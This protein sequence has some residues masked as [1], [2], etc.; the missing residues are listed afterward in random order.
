M[1]DTFNDDMRPEFRHY[2]IKRKSG[3]YPWGSGEDEY[4]RALAFYEIIGKLEAR[5][6]PEKEMY[7]ALGL[8]QDELTSSHIRSTRTIA[9]E[10]KV[11]QETQTAVNMRERGMS[12]KAIAEETGMSIATVRNRLKNSEDLK[13][14]MLTQ[15][16]SVLKKTVDEH[17]IVDIGKGT[18]L[19]MGVS[20]EKLKAA[21][22]LLRDEDYRTHS[23]PISNPGTRFNTNTLVLVKPGTTWGDAVKMAGKLHTMGSWTED[24]GLT[25]RNLRDPISLSSKRLKVEFDEDGGSNSDGLIRVRPGVEDVSMGKNTYAQVRILVD[26]SHYLKGMAVL[27]HKMEPGVDVIFSTN[28]SRSVGKLGALKEIEADPDNPFGSNIKR[29]I[30][31]KDPKTGV[32]KATSALN[33]VNEE[34]DWDTWRKSVPSQM[35]A[36]QPGA[37][38]ASQLQTTR[39]QAR[40]RL[41]EINQITN[42]VVRKKALADYADQV[43]ADAVDLRAAQFPR[44]QTKVIIPMPKLREDEIYAPDYT[45][46]ERVV[47]IRY[48]HGGRF[49]IPEVTVNNN[50]RIAKSLLGNAR[51]AIGI[52]PK[53]AERLSGADFDGDT[54]IV[55]PN[56]SGKIKSAKSLSAK[57]TNIYETNLKNFNPKV[58]Y[59]GFVKTG[60][61]KNGKDVGN[62]PLMKNTGLEMG[63]ITNLITDMQV[64]GATPEHVVR[65][66]K[67]SMVVI[68]AEKHKLNYK[69]SEQ[70]HNIAQL[71]EL[72]QGKSNSGAKTLLSRATAKIKVDERKIRPMSQG[73]PIDKETGERVYVPT[74]RRVNVYDAKTGTYRDGKDGRPL[75][76]RPVEGKVKRLEL[77]NNAF[78]LVR[79]PAD[80][81]ERLYAEHANEMKGIANDARLQAFN[82][83]APL[84]SPQAA[85]RYQAEVEDLVRQLKAAE[86]QKPL[87]RRANTIAN[88]WIKAKRLEDET[89]RFDADRMQKVERQTKA[90]ARHRLGL[91]PVVIDI[92]DS[93]WD[94]IQSGAISS[95]RLTK[96]LAFTDSK[97]I[98]ELAMPRTNTVMTSAVVSRAKAMLA[99]GTLSTEEVAS[100]LGVSTSTLKAAQ[101]RGDLDG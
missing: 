79:D 62:F 2:G 50:S 87:S 72:Y 73:G 95:S 34:G 97:R 91:K 11:Q 66:V 15:T 7:L 5:G 43:D 84:R 83:K 18:E 23:I 33:L 59:G 78:D 81:V 44:Q 40:H 65:A 101:S 1:S 10:V 35:L 22:S 86:I 100:L 29:Q 6:I 17:D 89:L 71:K 75:E 70:Y 80:P 96:I 51:D 21:T 19:L 3:R 60:V 16:A 45:N 55:I 27:D 57:D 92:T 9:K 8:N 4:S 98:S 26:G 64:Q 93:Q 30:T 13:A 85:K 38:I 24:D 28:K 90:A 47:L 54:V 82:T 49:E 94:A 58:Q 36:K 20:V 68:D 99:A 31:E 67:H 37:L 42:A 32:E 56:A 69:A 74:G 77:T 88:E 25:Y 12:P 41:A 53:V 46:G 61:D 52:H 39:D 48:P 63:R 14:S 76:T